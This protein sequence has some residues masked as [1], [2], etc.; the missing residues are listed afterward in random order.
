V[1][2]KTSETGWVVL[3][4]KPARRRWLLGPAAACILAVLL[5]S[6]LACRRSAPQDPGKAGGLHPRV[7]VVLKFATHPAL[8]ETET[9]VVEAIEAAKQGSHIP[10]TIRVERLNANGS[11]QL[12]KQLAESASRPGVLLIVAIATP[13][14]QAV[15]KTPSAIPIVYGAVADPEGAGILASGRATGIRNVGAN[16]IEAALQFIRVA[17]PQ[18]VELGT[19]YNPAEQNSVYVQSLLRVLAPRYGF[20][21]VPAEVLDKTQVAGTVELLAR[22]S[23]V[24]YSANDNTINAAAAT[25][26]AVTRSTKTPFV[27]GDLSTLKAG[28]LAAVGLEY[29]Q[30]GRDV[31]RMAVSVLQGV[32][33]SDLPPRDPPA[34][35][36]WLNEET[37]QALG[38]TLPTA[39]QALV[40]HTLRGGGG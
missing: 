3:T 2:R 15:A 11:P 1:S 32:P 31:G 16:I 35:Q 21:L 34:P 17:F 13:A 9:G 33:L 36:V 40:Q 12:A 8:D 26:V 28:A 24:L 39:A 37:R 27:I 25:V 38:V 19:P 29:R 23:D 22:K 4:S 14:A 18:A 5:A 6:A 30:L 10:R 20:V 7:V